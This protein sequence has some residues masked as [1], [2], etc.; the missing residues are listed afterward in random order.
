MRIF[1]EKIIN[2]GI[3]ENL[4]FY[5]KREIRIINV[6]ALI[7]LLGVFVGF[8]TLFFIDGNYLISTSGSTALFAIVVLLLNFKGFHNAASLTFLISINVILFVLNQVYSELVANYL[9]YFPLIFCVALIHNP[10]K[11]NTRSLLLYAVNIISFLCSR[12]IEIPFLKSMNLV[13]AENDALYRYNTFLSIIITTLLVYL[14][15]RRINQQNDETLELLEKEQAS[16]IKISQ[17]LNEK[18]VLLAE[19]QHRVKNNL[20]IIT[21]LL[22]LQS[23]KAPCDISRNLMLES[24]NRVMSIAM[25]HDRLYKKDNLAKIDLQNYLSELIDEIMLSFSD[26]SP[27]I[28]LEKELFYLEAE[29]TKA[30]PIGLIVNEAITN[31]LKHAFLDSNKNPCLNIKMLQ[32]EQEYSIEISDNGIGFDDLSHQTEK[33]LGL[34]LIKSLAHQI[35]GSVNFINKGGSTVSLS[36]N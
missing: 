6:F 28:N 31:T 3:K 22:K 30:V 18:E 10:K 32:N 20:A 17:S 33:N 11:S 21:A 16:Q 19:I 23:E 35:D 1:F 8:F 26:S 9:Y 36:F 34:S 15:V 25:V 12:F 24:K 14:V 5:Q 29:I 4:D 27:K 7:T 2:L 13:G